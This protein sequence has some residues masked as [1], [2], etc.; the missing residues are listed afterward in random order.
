MR[1]RRFA[2]RLVA[3]ALI[4]VVGLVVQGCTSD[5]DDDA[6]EASTSTAAAGE[7]GVLRLGVTGSQT[8]DP[9]EVVATV[10]PD[11]IAVDLLYDGL[12]EIDP[13]TDAPSPALAEEWDVDDEGT[14]WTF[15]L[16]GDAVF[17]DGSQVTAGDVKASLERVAA[18]GTTSLP[19]VRLGVIDGYE[20]FV[21]GDA[22]ELAGLVAVDDGTLEVV[23]AEPFQP[24]PTLLASPLYGVLPASD[25]ELGEELFEEPVG[26]G[27]MQLT[28]RTDEVLRFEPVADAG[29][30]VAGVELVEFED[31]D[32]SYAA[33]SDGE[34]DW[35]LVPP[36]E[37]ENAAAEVG[38]EQVTPF[39]AVL[40]FGINVGNPTLGDRTFRKA[41]VRAVDRPA[42][43][44]E[45]S[46]FNS[47]QILNGL[48]P[49]GVP[50]NTDD[51]CGE[52]CEHDPDAAAELLEERFGDGEVPEVQID[53]PDEERERA[54]SELVAEDLEAVGIPVSLRPQAPEEY[55]RFVTS[56]EQE[57]FL[58]GWVGIA[59][60]PDSYLAPLFLSDSLDNVLA[61]ED[62]GT[63]EG[64]ADARALEDEQDR[65]EAYQGV[66]ARVLERLPIIPIAQ[67]DT[68]AVVSDRVEGWT[69]R[70]D[71]T[72]VLS[73]VSVVVE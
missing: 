38:E 51:A 61:Y 64:I 48:I 47:A 9:A 13:E 66:E 45:L 53:F 6:D 27:P 50:G 67:F 4:I 35:S 41:M 24:L 19:G 5:S 34:V 54:L 69:P 62:P 25:E 36:G 7:R 1:A 42:A 46:G 40:F 31:L 52:A 63:D 18:V 72:F 23:T 56:S 30:G 49:E 58:F 16:A 3:P 37:A 39:H 11:M 26:S 44:E 17:S 21:A 68:V 14:T 28:E 65:V 29:L 43:V 10:R 57:V 20:E 70:L 73:E 12:T 22:E 60:T 2:A 33:F 32:A 59:P 15:S 8:L 71:G 55:Q